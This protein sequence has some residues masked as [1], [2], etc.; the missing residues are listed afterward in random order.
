MS[1]I[2]SRIEIIKE[3]AAEGGA[4]TTSPKV[5]KLFNQIHGAAFELERVLAN[6]LFDRTDEY[7]KE[8]HHW[9]LEILAAL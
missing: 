5:K 8:I 3:A 9:G 7:F 2:K 4:N 1:G 6:K